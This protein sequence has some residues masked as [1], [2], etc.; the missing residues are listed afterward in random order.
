MGGLNLIGYGIAL[1]LWAM[2]S[3]ALPAYLA[4][5]AWLVLR[6]LWERLR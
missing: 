1:T 2:L 5:G 6:D 3:L 4:F